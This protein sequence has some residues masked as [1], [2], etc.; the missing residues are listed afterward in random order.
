MDAV[1]KNTVLKIPFWRVGYNAF[2]L[3][4]YSVYAVS[5]ILVLEK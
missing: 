4:E 2:V 1:G 5:V 3:H